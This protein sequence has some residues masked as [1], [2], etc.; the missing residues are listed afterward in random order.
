L[1]C[2]QGVHPPNCLSAVPPSLEIAKI[3]P[4]KQTPTST[5]LRTIGVSRLSE[6]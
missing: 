1:K 6:E 5:N 4:G 2:S 3:W